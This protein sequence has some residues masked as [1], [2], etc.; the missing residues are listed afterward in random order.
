MCIVSYRYH[1]K[2]ERDDVE[3][4]NVE[5]DSTGKMMNIEERLVA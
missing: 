1:E 3:G 5:A 4:L 2:S